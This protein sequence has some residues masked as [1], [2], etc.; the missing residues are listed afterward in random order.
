ME[1]TAGGNDEGANDTLA[2]LRESSS[3]PTSTR[4]GGG[5]IVPIFG[6]IILVSVLVI[7]AISLV[8]HLHYAGKR[9]IRYLMLS[10][11]ALWSTAPG[12]GEVSSKQTTA[13]RHNL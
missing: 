9:R 11:K 5:G 2:L 10:Y 1:A 6:A 8:V 7:L 4:L 3:L 12:Q 13:K